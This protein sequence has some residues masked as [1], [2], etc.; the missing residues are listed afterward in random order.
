MSQTFLNDLALLLLRLSGLGMALAH[1][2]GKVV[3]LA[4]GEGGG[5]IAGVESLGFPLP[6]L[7]AWAAALA[8]FLGGLCVALGLGTRVAAASAGFAMFVAAF[9]RHH[10]LQHLLVAVGAMQASEETVRSWG[11]PELALLYLLAFGTLVLT[12]GGRLS[13]D[14]VLPGR[15]R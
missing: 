8:E 6:G 11:N 2:Y 1:G 10:A 14:R 12:G 4:A 3:A 9:V 13:L 7:F 15:R 5:F